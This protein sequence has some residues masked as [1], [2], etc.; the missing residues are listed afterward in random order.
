VIV[1]DIMMPDM[2]GT[3]VA[4]TLKKDPRTRAIPIIFLSSLISTQ[5]E[6]SNVK[7]D[8]ISYLSKPL[9]REK[10]LDE[11]RRYLAKKESP[12]IS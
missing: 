1:L 2:E 11:I 5:E 7:K 9:N 10:L 3:E 6:R 8:F 12:P 4:S